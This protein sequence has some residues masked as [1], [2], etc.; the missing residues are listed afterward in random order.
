MNRITL[1]FVR[2]GILT[3]TLNSIHGLSINA[4]IYP[5]MTDNKSRHGA[6]CV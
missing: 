1:T 4:T 2:N 3:G 5:E 6:R